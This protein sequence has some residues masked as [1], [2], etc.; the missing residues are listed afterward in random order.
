MSAYENLKFKYIVKDRNEEEYINKYTEETIP[1][2]DK[3]IDKKSAICYD[4][5]K[6][7]EFRRIDEMHCTVIN[8]IIDSKESIIKNILWWRH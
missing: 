5:K 6:T 2:S 7:V 3:H 4:D 8:D 1:K